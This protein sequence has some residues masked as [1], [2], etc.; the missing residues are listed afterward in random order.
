MFHY[1]MFI[2]K[3]KLLHTVQHHSLILLYLY[4]KSTQVNC[5]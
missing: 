1:L 2:Y 3:A 5:K 4:S